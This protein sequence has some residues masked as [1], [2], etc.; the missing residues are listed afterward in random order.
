MILFITVPN[1]GGYMDNIELI[2]I[3]RKC[4]HF[5]YHRANRQIGKE[6]ALLALLKHQPLTQ[7]ELGK[8]VNVRAS[9]VSE[10]VSK[11]ENEGL[12]L[13]KRARLDSR[14]FSITLTHEGLVKANEVEGIHNDEA[15]RL[16]GFL[17]HDERETLA[18]ILNKLLSLWDIECIDNLRNCE[19][20]TSDE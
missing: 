3:L 17:D 9:S 10:L 8:I 13:K 11:M 15:M 16:L 5:L 18:R 4:S 20:K 1:K 2:N 19:E 7:T 14:S 6:S 12:I